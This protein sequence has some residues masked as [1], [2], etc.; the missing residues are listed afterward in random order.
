MERAVRKRSK[1]IACLKH[2]MNGE[3][4]FTLTEGMRADKREPSAYR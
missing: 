3:K 1:G 4:P 2:R